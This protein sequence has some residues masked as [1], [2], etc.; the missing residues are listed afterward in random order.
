[1]SAGRDRRR[2]YL[3]AVA[4]ASV[5]IALLCYFTDA[6]GRSE[7][8]TVD[9]RFTVRGAEEPPDDLVVVEIDDA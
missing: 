8:D 6:L 5:A 1:M 4:A 7:L 2:L 3:V 9:A